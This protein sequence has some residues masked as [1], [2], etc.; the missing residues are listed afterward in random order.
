MSAVLGVAPSLNLTF[1]VIIKSVVSGSSITGVT[2]ATEYFFK[3]FTI[4]S[5]VASVRFEPLFGK[6]E[7]YTLP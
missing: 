1:D 4:L 7:R 2:E 3:S 5:F 6:I